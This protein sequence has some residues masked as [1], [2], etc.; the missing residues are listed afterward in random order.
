MKTILL[1]ILSAVSVFGLVGCESDEVVTTTTTT[2][3]THVHQPVVGG[4]TT[5]TRTIEN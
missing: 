2:E 1:V 4:T 5:T 3:E